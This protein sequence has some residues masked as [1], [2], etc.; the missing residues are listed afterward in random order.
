MIID[1]ANTPR[2]ELYPWII[3]CVAPRPIAWVSTISREGVTNLAP[4]SFFTAISSVPPTLC[5]VPGRREDTGGKKD[6]LLN[7]EATGDFVINV[8]TE[9]LAEAMNETATDFPHGMSEFDAA[10]LTPAPSERVKAPRLKESPVNF[11]CVRYE[12]IHIGPEGAGGGSLVI[13]RVV[14]LHVDESILTNGKVDYER[15]HPVGRLGGMDYSKT[16]DRFTMV[17]KKYAPKP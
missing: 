1:P 14:L 10:G 15:Y 5:F 3:R 4:F 6:T 8:V 2:S 9:D 7:I 12:I 11:E 16:R 17:R 13:G